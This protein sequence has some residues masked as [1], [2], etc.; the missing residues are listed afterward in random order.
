MDERLRFTWNSDKK[1]S[2]RNGP[3]PNQ[4]WSS[5]LRSPVIL[6]FIFLPFCRSI[7]SLF[8]CAILSPSSFGQV[9]VDAYFAIRNAHEHS[10]TMGVLRVMQKYRD[11]LQVQGVGLRCMSSSLIEGIQSI[12]RQIKCTSNFSMITRVLRASSP[13][14]GDLILNYSLHLSKCRR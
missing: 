3:Y 11:D 14:S 6:S 1:G 2:V 12:T 10:G 5:K 13:A 4:K 8:F 9:T 7:I